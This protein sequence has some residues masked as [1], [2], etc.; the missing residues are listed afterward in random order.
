MS[1]GNDFN[2]RVITEFRANDGK[3]GGPF[4]GADLLLLTTTGAKSGHERVN[5]VM[6]RTEGDDLYV[7]ASKSGAPT[8][9]DWFRNLVANPDVGVEFGTDSFRARAEVI[10]GAERDRIYAAHADRY[11][12]FVE[13]QDG[14][15]RVIPVV[16]LHKV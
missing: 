12:N 8:N 6:Y 2:S 14:L 1:D 13:Y 3:L 16:L 4:E 15:D 9:P 5:P 10:T 7:F 11:P